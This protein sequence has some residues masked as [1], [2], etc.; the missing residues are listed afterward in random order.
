MTKL[1]VEAAYYELVKG[2]PYKELSQLTDTGAFN[3]FAGLGVFDDGF[4]DNV[5]LP[6]YICATET[7]K[8]SSSLVDTY[9]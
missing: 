5:D 1:F 6:S 4:W 7:D 9:N 3:A 8:E 2:I